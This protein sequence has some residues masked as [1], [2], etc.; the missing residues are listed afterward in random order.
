MVLPLIVSM[1]FQVL[2]HSPL[3]VLFTFPSRYWFAI[4][5]RVVL[6][7]RRWA[8]QIHTGFH[9]TRITWER[10]KRSNDFRLRDYHALW[11][12]LSSEVRLTVG[13]VT[14]PGTRTSPTKRPATPRA[15]RIRS[16]T[17]ARFGLFRVRSP[18]LAESRF[19]FFSSGY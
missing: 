10:L 2:F 17:C 8:S 4:G 11:S 9:V 14:S 1:R 7:L 3:G 19:S 5:H 15:Q 16:I 13:L 12:R 18:L 6:S